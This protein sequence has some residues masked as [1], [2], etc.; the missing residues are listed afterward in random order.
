MGFSTIAAATIVG[1][2]FIIIL[3]TI[4]GEFLPTLSEVN[5][6]YR[7]IGRRVLNQVHT[8]INITSMDVMTPP[9]DI[10]LNVT[11]KNTGSV[12]LNTS[13]F[14]II[15]NGSLQS[16]NASEPVIYPENEV[17]F[18][19]NVDDSGPKSIKVFTGNG[20]AD[21]DDYGG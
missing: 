9:G 14:S 19:V 3:G 4:S 8:G 21:Y 2:S 7:N 5:D 20:V 12:I 1:L 6:S 10:Y 16:F 11:I 13:D 17:F 18:L 15:V